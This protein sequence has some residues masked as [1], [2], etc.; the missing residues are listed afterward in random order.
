MDRYLIVG[1]LL[2]I[3]IW[4]TAADVYYQA[5]TQSAIPAYHA[6]IG[7]ELPGVL[8]ETEFDTPRARAAYRDAAEAKATLHQMPCYCYCDRRMNHS[9]LLDCFKTRHASECRECMK[10]AIYVAQRVRDG[11]DVATI[12]TEVVALKWRSVALP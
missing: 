2:N 9:S 3:A 1:W 10:E 6:D 7:D 8:V 12:R 11:L 4:G 5:E